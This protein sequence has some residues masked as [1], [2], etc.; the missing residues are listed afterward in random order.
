LK[1]LFNGGLALACKHSRRIKQKLFR[2][3]NKLSPE[4]ASANKRVIGSG[5]SEVPG[6]IQAAFV[7]LQ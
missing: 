4:K 6:Q 5:K 7:P 1:G 2:L 3:D